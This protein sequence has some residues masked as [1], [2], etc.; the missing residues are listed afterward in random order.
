MLVF[1]QLID[2]RVGA[3]SGD[4]NSRVRRTVVNTLGDGSTVVFRGSGCGGDGV[5]TACDGPDARGVERDRDAVRGDVG[6]VA[7]VHVSGSGG[8]SAGAERGLFGAAAWTNG[9]LIE[10]T[11]GIDDPLGTTRATRVVNAGSRRTAVAQTLAV[12]GNFEYCL[13]VWA[14]TM[15]GSSVTLTMR[16]GGEDV[17]AVG[18]GGRG[19]RSRRIWD[20]G[21][22]R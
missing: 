5:G 10:L 12:P 18:T 6:D 16:D 19:F 13:S 20:R 2:G 9:A 4:Q 14:R 7:D 3:V 11:A 22:R 17:R 8:E 15:A 1:P 21:R